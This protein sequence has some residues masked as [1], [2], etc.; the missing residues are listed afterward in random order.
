M[1]SSEPCSEQVTW[2]LCS[3]YRHALGL[4]DRHYENIMLDTTDGKVMHVDFDVIFEKG[5]T[6]RVKERV[7][8]R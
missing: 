4:G 5:K 3:I 1:L 6:L 2:C 7:P 8:F